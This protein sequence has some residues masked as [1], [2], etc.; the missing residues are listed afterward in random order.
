MNAI[1]GIVTEELK[2][3]SWIPE[4]K[5]DKVIVW[6]ADL[7]NGT[8]NTAAAVFAL[9]PGLVAA[10]PVIATHVIPTLSALGGTILAPLGIYQT[11]RFTQLAYQAHIDGDREGAIR[12]AL[13]SIFFASVT[14]LGSFM[15]ASGSGSLSLE[16]SAFIDQIFPFIGFIL[17][18][19]V[20]VLSV[21]GLNEVKEFQEELTIEN[22]SNLRALLYKPEDPTHKGTPGTEAKLKRMISSHCV[23]MLRTFATNEMAMKK[24]VDKSKLMQFIIDECKTAN[25]KEMMRYQIIIAISV[26]GLTGFALLKYGINPSLVFAVTG[27]TWT[28]TDWDR[29]NFELGKKV[30]G[31]AHT[32]KFP[33][34][35]VQE[36]VD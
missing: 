2:G 35:Y 18:G 31:P 5:T 27:F 20:L 24:G 26:V 17:Y 1:Q 25:K 13:L 21:R 4:T 7:F 14:V 3:P 11:V 19:S 32:F 16:T 23:E 33:E 34:E 12:Y 8:R 36:F 6:G 28:L 15:I 10:N 29:L 30:H 9:S 22:W